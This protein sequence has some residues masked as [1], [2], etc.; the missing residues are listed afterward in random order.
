MRVAHVTTVDMSVRFL[1]R[2]QIRYLQNAGCDVSAIC[3]CGPWVEEIRASGLPVRV[4]PM[5]RAITPLADL[6]ALVRLYR[7]FRRERFAVVHTHTPKANLLGQLAACMARVPVRV[8]TLH[9][10]RIHGAM[11]G[12]ERRFYFFFDRVSCLCAHW[13]FSQ[14]R[15]DMA[16]AIREKVCPEW[17]VH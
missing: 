5:R 14:A 10:F 17:K 1:L 7:C 15:G 11:P 16:T 12:W 3:S 8:V 13:V 9:G 2:D 6:V 4:I